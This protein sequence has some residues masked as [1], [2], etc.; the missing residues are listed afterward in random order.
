MTSRPPNYLRHIIPTGPEWQV[1]TVS[2]VV[3]VRQRGLGL[4]A[5]MGVE[6]LAEA[7]DDGEEWANGDDR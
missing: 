6:E 3:F 7:V 2:G 5:T 1:K 4:V